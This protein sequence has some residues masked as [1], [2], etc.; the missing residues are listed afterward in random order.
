MHLAVG[1]TSL[2]GTLI[3]FSWRYTVCALN[4]MNT[5]SPTSLL[6]HNCRQLLLSTSPNSRR[7]VTV[8]SH[9]CGGDF[10]A[11]LWRHG[12][13]FHIW[14]GVCYICSSSGLKFSQPHSQVLMPHTH[15]NPGMRLGY[16]IQ[17]S[18]HVHHSGFII[19]SSLIPS[20]SHVSLRTR[21]HV[22]AS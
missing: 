5:L 21:L 17:I 3:S 9:A 12:S 16:S 2:L 18:V 22:C 7:W 15:E 19:R 11:V 4:N 6:K 14:A 13:E 10:P 20:S 1:W 8:Y